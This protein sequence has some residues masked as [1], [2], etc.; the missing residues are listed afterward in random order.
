MPRFPALLLALATALSAA[1]LPA[2]AE[3]RCGWIVNPT[4]GNWW[5]TDADGDWILMTQGSEG[6]P[7]MDLIPDLTANG[8]WVEVNGSYGYGCGCME[9]DTDG[10]ETVFEILSIR[11]LPLSRCKNDPALPGF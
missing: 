10:L 9:M 8:E 5:L 3:T 7:G 2:A 11:Q 1:A 4:P 6:V